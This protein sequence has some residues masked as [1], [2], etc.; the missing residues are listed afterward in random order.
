MTEVLDLGKSLH[1]DHIAQENHHAPTVSVKDA[2][3]VDARGTSIVSGVQAE[4]VL[5]ENPDCVDPT[6]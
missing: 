3:I 1:P 6:F 5:W 4:I 2:A